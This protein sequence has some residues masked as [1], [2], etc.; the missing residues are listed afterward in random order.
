MRT[1]LRNTIRPNTTDAIPF[2]HLHI[3]IK[4]GA[5]RANIVG[6]QCCAVCASLQHVGDV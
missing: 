5:N 4:A 3:C 2:Y 1:K 6:Q